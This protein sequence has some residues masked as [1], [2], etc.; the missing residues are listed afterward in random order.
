MITTLIGAIEKPFRHIEDP[1][2]F[3]GANEKT[4]N[5]NE[6]NIIPMVRQVFTRNQCSSMYSV[7][8][9]QPPRVIQAF[10]DP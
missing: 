7:G 4:L 3:L 2:D 5:Q 1:L 8:Q 9:I 10:E 6:N